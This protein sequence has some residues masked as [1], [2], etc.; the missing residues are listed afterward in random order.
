MYG[1]ECDTIYVDMDYLSPGFVFGLITV[2]SLC[3][4]IFTNILLPVRGK[5][6]RVHGR[7]FRLSKMSVWAINL[8]MVLGF[9]M[10]FAFLQMLVLVLVLFFFVI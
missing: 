7:I 8:Y 1:I 5:D 10:W 9:A 4:G 2:I 6:F 3:L